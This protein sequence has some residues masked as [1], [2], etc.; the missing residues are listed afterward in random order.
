MERSD[1]LYKFD[2]LGVYP[3]DLEDYSDEEM[4]NFLKDDVNENPQDWPCWEEALTEFREESLLTKDQVLK[5]LKELRGSCAD[6]LFSG[7]SD[8]YI[9]ILNG[10]LDEFSKKISRANFP[11]PLPDFWRYEFAVSIYAAKLFLVKI[12]YN[13]SLDEDLE[14]YCDSVDTSDLYPLITVPVSQLTVS[15]YAKQYGVAPVTVRQWIRRGRIRSAEKIQKE[16]LI[17]AL[18]EPPKDRGYTPGG[19]SWMPPLQKLPKE[20]EYLNRYS[21]A[22]FKK[23][24]NAYEIQLDDEALCKT[25]FEQSL[26]KHL[27]DSNAELPEYREA[28]FEALTLSAAER[29]KLERFMIEAAEIQASEKAILSYDDCD[30]YCIEG[31][32]CSENDGNNTVVIEV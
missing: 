22:R 27:E 6:E 12:N 25:E 4:L 20:Y 17:S 16:W 23:V 5:K 2:E 7:H 21:Y 13:F 29:E 3:S 9:K 28:T 19:Y 30:C 18:V 1:L 26:E 31:K 15:E 32:Y 14:G 8:S 24:R 10:V 11:E